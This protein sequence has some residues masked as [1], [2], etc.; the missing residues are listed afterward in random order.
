MIT[1]FFGGG[2]IPTYILMSRLKMVNTMWALV[3]PGAFGFWG[4]VVARTFIKATIPEELFEATSLDGGDYFDYFFRIVVPL[5]APIIAV[6][7]LNCAVGQ[8]NSYFSALIYIQDVDKY[9]LQIVLRSILIENSRVLISASSMGV[10]GLLTDVE[11]A[12]TRQYLSELL[13]YSLIIVSSA[14]L[15]IV[16]PFLQRFFVKGV[17][18]GSLKG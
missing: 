17:M 16:Y 1:M 5:S 2:L 3:I 15:L 10:S 7:A 14:P 6:L 9:P 4:A 12:M 8:W 11:T 18:I 13:K